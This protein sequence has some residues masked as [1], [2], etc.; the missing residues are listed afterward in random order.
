MPHPGI[1]WW[2]DPSW[3]RPIV[4]PDSDDRV[5]I[6]LCLPVSGS[7]GRWFSITVPADDVG[8]EL[9]L[10]WSDPESYIRANFTDAQGNPYRGP[11]PRHIPSRSRTCARPKPKINLTL[12]DLDL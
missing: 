10:L 1:D 7:T 12:E 6:S 8:Q 4:S 5:R 3:V 11:R 2:K 9:G